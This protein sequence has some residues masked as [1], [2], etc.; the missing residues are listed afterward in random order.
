MTAYT[1]SL[2]V[3][4]TYDQTDSYEYD[5]CGQVIKHTGHDPDGIG[6]GS[7]AFETFAYNYAGHPASHTDFLG[8]VTSYKDRSRNNFPMIKPA[9]SVLAA[10]VGTKSGSYF[11]AIP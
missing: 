8:N 3:Y 2:H 4:G 9:F 11:G 7:G 6:G 5:T 10:S 1:N